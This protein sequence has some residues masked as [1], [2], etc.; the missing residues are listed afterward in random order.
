M[1]AVAQLLIGIGAICGV[2]T[3]LAVLMVIADATI[4]NY[5]DVTVTIN[6]E[7]QV[8]VAGGKPLLGSLMEEKIFIPSACG[9]RGSCGLCKVKV[10]SDVGDYLP[11][12]LPWISDEEKAENIRLS[13]QLKL[14]KDISIRIPEELFNVREYVT[15]V[16]SLVDL[17]YDIKQVTLKLVEPD[18]I[19]YRPGQYIQFQV[20]EYELTP[21]SVYR[22]YS[23]SSQP[24]RGNEIELEIR[25]VPNGICTTYVFEHLREG[26]KVIVNGPYGEFFLRETDRDI[27]FIAGGSGMAPIK[28]ILYTM[29]EQENVRKARYFFGARA[30]RD[31]FLLDEMKDLE[32]RLPGFTFIPALSEPQPEDNWKGETGLITEV[33][34]KHVKSGD[35]LEAY[36]CGSPGM[37]DATV[38]VLLDKGIPEELIYYDKFA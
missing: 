5:G 21:E 16:A 3:F 1:G 24:S 27:V 35:N 23:M 9:G 34:S 30:V 19:S 25:L 18:T 6:D 4:A 8:T 14:K 13:C 32:T 36:L 22:A 20:P 26:D 12:E 11:T 38:K 37:I 7:K 15:E 2:S 10:T 33:L 31:L 17:T 29:A 28:S